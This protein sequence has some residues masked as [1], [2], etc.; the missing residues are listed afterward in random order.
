MYF[1]KIP[2]LKIE[3]MR[4]IIVEDENLLRKLRKGL[5]H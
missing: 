3:D 2:V 4:I 1:L 5:L